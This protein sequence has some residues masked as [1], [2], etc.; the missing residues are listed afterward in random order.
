MFDWAD[1]KARTIMFGKSTEVE[2]V[3]YCCQRRSITCDDEA[4]FLSLSS[5]FWLVSF[6]RGRKE[7]FFSFPGKKEGEHGKKK[8]SSQKMMSS[9]LMTVRLGRAKN[10]I[11]L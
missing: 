4:D 10:A 2:W 1:E 11:N 5:C 8:P 6:R 3:C 9:L 7:R